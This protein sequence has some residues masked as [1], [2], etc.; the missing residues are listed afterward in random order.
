MTIQQDA[1][2]LAELLLD[3]ET[4]APSDEL[5]ALHNELWAAICRH[6]VV[7]GLSTEDLTEIGNVGAAQN[8]GGGT[9]KEPPAG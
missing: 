7:L 6:R 4:A 1:I 3:A 8:R 5:T 9:P 2:T